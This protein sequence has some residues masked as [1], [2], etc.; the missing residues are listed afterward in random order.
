METFTQLFERD[1]SSN[2]V[3]TK[4]DTVDVSDNSR[5]TH[6]G[7][8]IDTARHYLPVESI[9]RIIDASKMSKFNVLHLHLVDAQ[10]FPF[11][12][13]SSSNI[14]KGAYSS[15]ATYSTDDIAYITDYAISRG[16]RPVFE[17]D[18]PGLKFHFQSCHTLIS[19]IYF[20]H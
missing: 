15:S 9:T 14:V 10:S 7:V 12:S 20:P 17:I 8:M 1:I 2:S 6:R 5:F 4:Y 13:P 11:D 19:W 16:I 3:V 18:V